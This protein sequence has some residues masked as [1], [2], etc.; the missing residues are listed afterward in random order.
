MTTPDATVY[1]YINLFQLSKDHRLWAQLIIEQMI[2]KV[3]HDDTLN[4]LHLS[5]STNYNNQILKF[6]SHDMNVLM[7]MIVI[8]QII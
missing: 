4:Q 6:D 2:D 8:L 7:I 1:Y 5:T 3:V